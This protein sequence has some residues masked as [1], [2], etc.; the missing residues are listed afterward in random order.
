MKI[1]FMLTSVFLFTIGVVLANGVGN[2]I[3]KEVDGFS[4]EF[5]I[6]PKEAKAGEKA[7]MSLSIHN[8]TTGEPLEINDL[9]IRISKGDKIFFTSNDF[10][11]KPYGPMFFGYIFEEKGTYTID[12]S[13][14]NIDKEIKTNFVV[15][16]KGNGK[17]AF[18]DAVILITAFAFGFI[19]ANFLKHSKKKQIKR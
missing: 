17:D 8:A 18:K 9:W 13:A 7:T 2:E 12:F 3:K 5:G 14:K 1:V 16:V 4:F 11:I 10:R 19:T 6:D 15:E